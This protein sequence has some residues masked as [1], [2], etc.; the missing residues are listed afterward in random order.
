MSLRYGII[1]FGI[2]IALTQGSP[3]NATLYFEEFRTVGALNSSI[4]KT[5]FGWEDT[6][7]LYVKLSAAGAAS[8]RSTWLSPINKE[9]LRSKNLLNSNTLTE[10]WLSP[11]SW[12]DKRA[13]GNWS[14]SGGLFETSTSKASLDSRVANFVIT[15]E[16]ASLLL[17][18]IGGVPLAAHIL[19]RRKTSS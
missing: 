19:R 16:P 18:G 15:P 5:V 17:F 9:Y 4:S 12:Q 7:Y 10:F 14:L 1:L 3:A 11:V 13:L 8:I 6:P 2:T